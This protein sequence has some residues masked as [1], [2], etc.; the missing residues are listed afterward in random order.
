MYKGTNLQPLSTWSLPHFYQGVWKERN[1]R[2]FRD[3]E[4]STFVLADKINSNIKENYQ[5][6]KGGDI[7]DGC[8][9]KEM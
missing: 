1:N 4:E 7:E 6:R 5:I 3:R 9:K 8:K 2:I